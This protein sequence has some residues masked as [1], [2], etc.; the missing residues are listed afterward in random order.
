M[1]IKTRTKIITLLVFLVAVL[2]YQVASSIKLISS[3][4]TY[5]YPLVLMDKTKQTI[6]SLGSKTNQLVHAQLFP[7]HNFRNVVRPNNDTLY[8]FTWF[9]LSKE[10][11]VLSV[12]ESP[13]RYYV[14][15]FMD[16]W[17][18]VFASVGTRET[19]AVAGEY[20]LTGPQWAGEVPEG[21]QQIKSPTN[22]VW[23][24]GRIQTNGLDDVEN[25]I[26]LQ[27]EFK[28]SSL[29]QW[30]AG[31][32][33]SIT[34]INKKDDGGTRDPYDEVYSMS[35]SE[36][37]TEFSRLWNENPAPIDDPEM[38]KQLAKLGVYPGQKFDPE[39]VSALTEFV[40][41][42]AIK[43]TRAIVHKQ[44]KNPENL[45]NGWAFKREGIGNYGNDYTIR[46]VISLI[47]LGALPPEE[48]VYPNTSLDSSGEALNGKN[49]Y[50]LH[51]AKGEVPPADAFWSLTMYD[52]E[53]FLIESAINRYSIGDRNK[54]TFN[55]DGSL[56]IIIQKE[57]P[58]DNVENWLPAPEGDFALT[59]RVYLPEE[60]LLNGQWVL[61]AV[62]KS[63]LTTQH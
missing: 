63:G 49:H 46:F 51:F 43:I 9:D 15:P 20:M 45:T 12:P 23:M 24:I 19:G 62:E 16:A 40:A 8:S 18:N 5:S 58:S 56:D 17:T 33:N 48:A 14:M 26:A 4:Y 2:G 6:L 3:V 53:G 21:V 54:L 11:Q 59:L 13:D 41:E 50:K 57:E 22:M 29:S 30:Q 44:L 1:K 36:F 27:G 25:V 34:L 31:I 42:I 47:G 61:P 7:D 10:P 28:L 39:S 38:N 52:S 32:E 37:L 35:F 60:R 55:Q